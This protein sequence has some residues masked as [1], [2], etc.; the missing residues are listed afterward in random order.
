MQELA[1]RPQ[2]AVQEVVRRPQEIVQEQARPQ[3]VIQEQ[4]RRPQEA[5][6]GAA[7]ERGRTLSFRRVLTAGRRAA[8]PD[9]GASPVRGAAAGRV[10]AAEAGVSGAQTRGPGNGKR[11]RTEDSDGFRSQGRPR[12][13]LR[14]KKVAQGCS[15]V[16]LSGE[17]G[18]LGAP[19]DFYVGNTSIQ[20]TDEK[21]KQ[22]LV[23]CA[24]G[25]QDS[26]V[27]LQVL[28]VEEIGKELTG[29]RTKCW[30]V[31]VPYSMKEI[32]QQSSLYPNSWTHRR[33]F[34]PRDKRVPAVSPP[35][36]RAAVQSTESVGGEQ[37]QVPRE[38]ERVPRVQ[39]QVAMEQEASEQV[40]EEPANLL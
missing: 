37:E 13:A 16:D 27:A 2:V 5:A 30:K 3:E 18:E 31:T 1:R 39:E 15:Q 7:M 22:V 32:M 17:L 36:C 8:T 11:T 26:T 25:L 29:R 33:F 20:V 40:Q 10:V 34:Q 28:N 19:L 14:Q 12:Q 21:V 38:Q 35:E 9:R 6:L 4:T 23:K 24:A